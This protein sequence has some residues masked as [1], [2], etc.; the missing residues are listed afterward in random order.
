MEELKKEWQDKFVCCGACDEQNK[1]M[2]EWITESFIPKSEYEEL[3]D[4]LEGEVRMMLKL[5]AAKMKIERLETNIAELKADNERLTFECKDSYRKGSEATEEYYKHKLTEARQS[6]RARIVD[7]L[8]A[9]ILFTGQ[10]DMFKENVHVFKGQLM[11]A[12]TADQPTQ[13]SCGGCE[14]LPICEQ[15]E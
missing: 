5:M 9:N 8:T 15:G 4:G 2:F 7:I 3:A 13:K 14:H 11:K 12:I 1:L 10:I 6:E